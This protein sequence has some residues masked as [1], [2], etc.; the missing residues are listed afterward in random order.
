MFWFQRRKLKRTRRTDFCPTITDFVEKR[1]KD[2]STLYSFDGPFQLVHADVGN[3]ELL[4]KNAT[5]PRNVVMVVDLYSSKIYGY[6]ICSR[7]Q[8]MKQFYD[9]VKGKRKNKRMRL[10]FDNEF[11]QVKLKDLNDENNVDMFTTAVRGWKAFAAEQKTRE[12]KTRIAKLNAQKL[13]I[14]PTN[15]VLNSA[16]NMNNMKSEKHGFSPEEIETKSLS[17]EMFRTMF[18]MHR[19]EKT[20]LHNRLD[21]YDQKKYSAKKRKLRENVM[22]GERVLV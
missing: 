9:E 11:Q 10:Q 14:S 15:I 22:T 7:K 6:P 2:R 17:N 19:I 13:K 5:I 18:N 3:F 4:G 12:L 16:Q 21:R 20:K 1:E 8:K